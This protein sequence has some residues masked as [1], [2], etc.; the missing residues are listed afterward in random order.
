MNAQEAHHETALPDAS[1]LRKLGSLAVMLLIVGVAGS[2][3]WFALYGKK[4][5][6][7][8]GSKNLT[9]ELPPTVVTIDTVKAMSAKRTI[10][11]VGSLYGKDELGIMPEVEGR[12][13]SLHKDVGDIVRG[14]ELLAVIDEADYQL[15]VSEA[16]RALE[17]ELSRLGLKS[18]PTGTFNIEELPTVV[19]AAAQLRNATARWQRAVNLR[20]QNASSV[21]ELQAAETERDFAAADHRQS[22]LNAEAVLAA[23]RHRA[24]MLQTALKRLQDTRVCAPLVA[25]EPSADTSQSSASPSEVQYVVVRR[26]VSPGQMVY[27]TPGM[28]TTL[29]ELAVINPLELRA[30]VPE[31][32]LAKIKVGQAVELLVD[33]YPQETFHGQISRI[34]PAVDRASRTFEIE[35][36]VPN[37][38]RRL[39]TGS[40]VKAQVVIGQD[41]NALGVPEAAIVSFAGVTKVYVYQ[42]GR[43]HE[44]PVKVRGDL[45]AASEE[46]W[47]EVEGQLEVG[48]QVVTSGQTRLA[49]GAEVVLK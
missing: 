11:V 40:F 17:A 36:A 10:S 28:S 32:Y 5:V 45:N 22:Q 16:E 12:L 42:D 48:Q 14:G 25:S 38:D 29:Y 8:A 7:P 41:D 4:H 23:A 6:E 15:A 1:W 9:L 19:R 13:V 43:V 26:E 2:G 21:E 47:V 37:A 39:A 49:E 31:Q 46:V 18:L 44:V 34:R 27:S 30:A 3:F 33:A 24:A 20:A 35:A